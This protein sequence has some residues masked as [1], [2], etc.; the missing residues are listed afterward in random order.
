[1][2][3]SFTSVAVVA[4][5]AL[6]APLLLSLTGLRLPAIVLEILLGI[7]VGPQGLGWASVDEPVAVMSLLGLALLLAVFAALASNLGLEAILGAF[8]AG[9]TLK[10]VDRDGAMTHPDFHRKLEAA[11]FGIFVPFFFVS[12]GLRL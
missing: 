11:G 5:V 3:I 10:L 4:A 9:A 12:T 8:L 7:A 2:E 6:V 1:M